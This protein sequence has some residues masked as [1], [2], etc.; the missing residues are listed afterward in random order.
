[1]MTLANAH[2]AYNHVDKT[3]NNS[4]HISKI[5]LVVFTLFKSNSNSCRIMEKK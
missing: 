1:M 3:S 5:I 4:I 2:K